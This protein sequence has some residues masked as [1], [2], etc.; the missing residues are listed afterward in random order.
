MKNNLYSEL[1][2]RTKQIFKSVVESYLET[3]SPSGSE[4]VLKRAGLDISSASVRTV[5]SNLQK[6]GLLFSPHTSAGRVPTEKGMRFFVDGLLEFGRI[7]KSEKENIEQLGSSKSKSYQQVLD[8]ASRAISGLSNYAGIVIAPKYQKKLKHLEFIRLNSKQ[9]MSILAYENGEIENRIIE[10]SGKFTNSQL[11]QVSN[12][13]DDKFRNKNI[14]EIKRLVETEI[15]KSKSS[16]GCPLLCTCFR[17]MWY[18]RWLSAC[19]LFFLRA[20]YAVTL[21]R[22]FLRG[23]P[24]LRCA[25]APAACSVAAAAWS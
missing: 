11:L 22:Y 9:I 8:E 5:L 16:L 25:S 3:G 12:Y 17:C 23:G 14:A 4:T 2:E 10:D 15:T 19:V 6:E 1:S 20:C 24:A 13:L 21:C 7:S 18:D